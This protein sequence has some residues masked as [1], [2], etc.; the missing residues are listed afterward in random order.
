MPYICNSQPRV[1]VPEGSEPGHLGVRGPK[2]NR[3]MAEKTQTSKVKDKIQ[4]KCCEIKFDILLTVY[5]YV[6]Q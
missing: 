5:H 1:R 6:S 4:V 2:K 3:I